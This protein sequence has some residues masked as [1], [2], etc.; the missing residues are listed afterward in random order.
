VADNEPFSQSTAN[1]ASSSLLSSSTSVSEDGFSSLSN[2]R[3]QKRQSE[4]ETS[5]LLILN[6]DI[7][8]LVSLIS[9]D[10]IDG[11]EVWRTVSF[12]LLDSLVG[13]SRSERPHRVLNILSRRGYLQNFVQGIKDADIQLQQVLRP[14]PSMSPFPCLQYLYQPLRRYAE[15][16]IRL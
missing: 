1:S 3:P 5:A 2:K 13:L 8:G 12:T 9:T 15:S 6:K 10:A 4:L 7:D 11:M 14:D 16:F